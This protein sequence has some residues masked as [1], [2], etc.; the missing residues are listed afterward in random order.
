MLKLPYTVWPAF[1]PHT[2]HSAI[3]H[4][5]VTVKESIQC[6]TATLATTHTYLTVKTDRQA[7]GNG[8][9]YSIES[10]PD[11]TTWLSRRLESGSCNL[12]YGSLHLEPCLTL[13]NYNVPLVIR[14]YSKSFRFG[15]NHTKACST[16]WVYILKH[17]L[18]TTTFENIKLHTH[19]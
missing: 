1:W 15:I 7:R 19:I 4:R 16:T 9:W 14:T 18:R 10:R 11:M 6:L 5:V 2:P 12:F 3:L 17:L 8:G 13:A